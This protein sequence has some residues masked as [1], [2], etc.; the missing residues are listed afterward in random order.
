[1]SLVPAAELAARETARWRN[2]N[3]DYRHWTILDSTPDGRG[4]DWYPSL[5]YPAKKN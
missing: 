2:E 1:M 5:T 3:A 4:A